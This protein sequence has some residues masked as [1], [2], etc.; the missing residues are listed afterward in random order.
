MLS[1]FWRLLIGTLPSQ[2]Q[3]GRAQDVL[4]RDDLD[5]AL[6]EYARENEYALN[7]WYEKFNALHL[8]LSKRVAREER[9]QGQP[10]LTLGRIEQDEKPSIVHLRRMGSV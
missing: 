1:W 2:T 4:T 9:K 7:E 5:K 3:A 8:R 6:E 10:Q